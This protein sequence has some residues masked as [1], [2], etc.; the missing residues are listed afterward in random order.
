MEEQRGGW[1]K[2]GGRGSRCYTKYARV[3]N[4]MEYTTEV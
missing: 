2:R 3:I 1:G 4:I